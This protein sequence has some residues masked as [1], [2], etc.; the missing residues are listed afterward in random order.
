VTTWEFNADSG[1]LSIHTEVSGRAAR[2]G[3]RLTIAVQSWTATLRW[4]G[5]RPDPV[6]LSADLTSIAVERGDGGLTA[7]TAPE[8]LVARANALKSLSAQRYPTVDYAAE[9][10]ATDADRYRLTGNLTIH[11]HSRP[12]IVDVIATESGDGWRL[13]AES[14]VT[15]SDFGI[16]PFSLM[17]GS[18]RVADPV[19]VRFT[20]ERQHSM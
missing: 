5:E 18:L 8:K 4:D 11:G 16:T 7:L 19:T 9:D 14:V 17:L 13:S 10:I 1:S 3:H 2:L 6:R 15:Q 12:H 20:A